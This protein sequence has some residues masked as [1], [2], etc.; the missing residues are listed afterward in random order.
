[1]SVAEFV[2]RTVALNYFARRV[3]QLRG[4]VAI[5]VVDVLNGSVD[6]VEPFESSR[7]MA[8]PASGS[9]AF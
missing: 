3:P 2:P 8:A 7:N 1:V 4:N 9:L 5:K 6:P